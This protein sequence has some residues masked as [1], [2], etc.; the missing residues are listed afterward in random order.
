MAQ[1]KKVATRKRAGAG[2]QVSAKTK[3]KALVTRKP[4][5]ALPAKSRTRKPKKSHIAQTEINFD[6]LKGNLFRTI[7][8]DGA[9]GGLTPP[10]QIHMSFFSERMAIPRRVTMVAEINKK[11]GSM[12]LGAEIGRETRDSIVREMEVDVIMNL[13]TAE[14]VHDWLGGQIAELSKR[15]K[16]AARL[17]AKGGRKK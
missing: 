7:H 17:K 12:A 2:T 10:G 6:Y 8:T 5:A 9:I 3:S 13:G 11:T 15:E 4:K 14:R 16:S 1:K